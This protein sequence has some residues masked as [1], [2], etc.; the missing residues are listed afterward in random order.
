VPADHGARV[1]TRLHVRRVATG[2]EDETPSRPR[3]R[4]ELAVKLDVRTSERWDRDPR[5]GTR[6]VPTVEV[7]IDGI[8]FA[9]DAASD[10]AARAIAVRIS[11]ALGL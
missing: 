5:H 10:D 8:R 6:R 2:I 3:P 11:K 7:W 1:A 4:A 9:T